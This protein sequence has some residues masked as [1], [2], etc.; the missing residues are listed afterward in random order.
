MR[1]IEL[2][3]GL[4]HC[5]ETVAKQEFWSS[6]NKYMENE[7]EDKELKD[8][9]E[10]LKVKSL[11][12]CKKDDASTSFSILSYCYLLFNYWALL[13]KSLPSQDF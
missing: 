7:Q 1:C 6:V 12:L 2:F 13:S 5:I 11:R 8:K 9:I 4:S 10:L 3:P